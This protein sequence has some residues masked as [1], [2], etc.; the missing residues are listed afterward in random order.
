M[1]VHPSLLH[2]Y[3]SLD[4]TRAQIARI[5]VSVLFLDIKKMSSNYLFQDG[6]I[7]TACASDMCDPLARM[8]SYTCQAR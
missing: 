7:C 6:M 8:P 2:L 5:V 4:G 3:V 1:M